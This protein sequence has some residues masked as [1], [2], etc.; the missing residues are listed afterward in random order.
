MAVFMYSVYG[1]AGCK[2]SPYRAPWSRLFHGS[3][4][5]IQ[6][7]L[8]CL[9]AML[10]LNYGPTEIYLR[11]LVVLELVLLF[12]VQNETYGLLRVLHGL[13]ILLN[14]FLVC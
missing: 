6:G 11:V 8:S 7:C 4:C 1:P 9:C 5:N 14:H 12:G 2:W 13:H 3:F 10:V